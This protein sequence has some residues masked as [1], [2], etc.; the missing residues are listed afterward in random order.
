MGAENA[1]PAEVA[2]SY[3][4]GP[5]LRIYAP[6]FSLEQ[7]KIMA[8]ELTDAI[9]HALQLEREH[10]ETIRIHFCT[11]HWDNISVGGRLLSETE[12]HYY[13]MEFCG[14]ALNQECKA[15]LGRRLM[16]LMQELLNV[17]ASEGHRISL[18]FHE[19]PPGDL[20]MGSRRVPGH[21][22]VGV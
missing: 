9:A 5:Y 3:F 15:A 2:M 11:C 20:L 17:P 22:Q 8:A 7:R 18:I 13:H 6:E 12:E 10:R 21:C 14:R 16:P 4:N 1:C 19:V